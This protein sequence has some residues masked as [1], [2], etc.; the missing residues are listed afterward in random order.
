M[1]HCF[2]IL[3]DRFR[4]IA[5]A[6]LLGVGSEAFLARNPVP[7]AFARKASIVK[8]T[9][10]APALA[11]IVDTVVAAGSFKT[12]AAAL[13]ATGPFTVFAP[14]DEAFAKLPKGTVG[15][16]LKDIP[17]LTSILTYNV[18]PGMAKA[19]T[20]VGLDGHNIEKRLAARAWRSASRAARSRCPA[21]MW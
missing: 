7:P 6:L 15:A 17:K 12:L 9:V 21:L 16:L 5:F 14:T 20:V 2:L 10:A 18:V 8:S 1:L 11:E 4:S 13:S 3:V 19:E